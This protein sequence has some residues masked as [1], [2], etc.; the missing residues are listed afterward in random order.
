MKQFLI[1]FAL[2]GLASPLAA[3]NQFRA[4]LNGLQETPPN[5]SAAVGWG[6]AILN[7]SGTVTYHVETVGLVATSAHI[8]VGAVGVPGGII[9]TLSGGPTTWDGTSAAPLSAPD[10]ASL[11]AGGTYFNVHTAAF[12][13]GEIRGQILATPAE[14]AISADESQEV[15]PTGSAA[16]ATGTLI[17]NPDRS[18]TYSIFASGISASSAHIHTGDAGVNGPIL[19]TLAGGP[20]SW[21]GTTVP[22]TEVEYEVL[23][24]KGMYV[25]IHEMSF[26]FAGEIRGQII[27][28]GQSYGFGCPGAGG[29]DAKLLAVGAPMAGQGIKLAVL[30][31]MPGG[32]G[33][34][35]V[36]ASPTATLMS[37]CQVFVK[38]PLLTT[39]PVAL[40]GAGNQSMLLMLPNIPADRTFF[41][42]FGGFSGGLDYTSNAIALTVEVL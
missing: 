40:D 12:G 18:I 28:I 27:S 20:S 6:T 22:M 24:A 17:V 29:F 13:G 14:F 9:V 11:R 42:Q 3:Q 41:L 33:R 26:P 38:L 37:G 19:F 21:S 39:I 32:A 5:A 31:G 10:I 16:T 1:P 7:A 2:L 23:Q 8:H 30:D 25:N 36:S 35:A 34:V 15:P 4:S